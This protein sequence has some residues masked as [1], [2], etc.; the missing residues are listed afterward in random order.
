MKAA[1]VDHGDGVVIPLEMVR[2]SIAS[3][4]QTTVPIEF[5]REWKTSEVIWEKCADGS[6]RVSPV[7]DVLELFGALRS[8][9]PRDRDEKRKGRAA[10]ARSANKIPRTA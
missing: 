4:G 10:L 1:D 6:A 2:T 9:L 5:R 3:K 8:K 7:T